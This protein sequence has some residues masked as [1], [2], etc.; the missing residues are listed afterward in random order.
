MT[1]EGAAGM[2]AIDAAIE[3]L[4]NTVFPSIQLGLVAVAVSALQEKR[5]RIKGADHDGENHA[6]I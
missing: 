4:Q 5:E 2:D 6:A 1:L 3:L